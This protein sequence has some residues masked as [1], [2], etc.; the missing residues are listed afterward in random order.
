[1]VQHKTYTI[2]TPMY[3]TGFMWNKGTPLFNQKIAEEIIVD[4][5]ES[6]R[7]KRLNKLYIKV[8]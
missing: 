3:R 2:Y 8:P 5:K 7:L 6:R 1:M 4:W